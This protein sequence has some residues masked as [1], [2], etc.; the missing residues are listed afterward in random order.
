VLGIAFGPGLASGSAATVLLTLS[1]A[2]LVMGLVYGP[3]GAWLPQLF[4]VPLRYTGIS[5]AFNTGGIIG[6]AVT[7]VL[8]QMMA[9]AGHGAQ[10]G[11]L[12]SAAGVV[13]LIGVSLA[14]RM[15][16]SE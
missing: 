4:P 8:A 13:T 9:T 15:P 3:L 5:V 7:P 1:F 14:R 11:W 2:L 10:A 16:A 6:G 12:L